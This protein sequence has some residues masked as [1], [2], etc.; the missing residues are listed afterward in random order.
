MISLNGTLFKY[1]VSEP[2]YKSRAVHELYGRIRMVTSKDKLTVYHYY[3]PGLLD[4]I[5]FSRVGHCKF[6]I[7][8]PF[9][10]DINFNKLGSFMQVYNIDTESVKIK[11]MHILTGRQ[12]WKVHA[13][14]KK[15][16]TVRGL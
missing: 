7:P 8:A 11:E 12:H 9:D 15:L 13:I 14:N 6:F 10:K 1:I 2:K 4:N 5:L 3:H 16:D